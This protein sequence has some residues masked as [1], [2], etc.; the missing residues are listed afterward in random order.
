MPWHGYIKIDGTC[1]LTPLLQNHQDVMGWWGD[2]SGRKFVCDW[3]GGQEGTK[4]MAQEHGAKR[5]I[6]H[7]P[8]IVKMSP[9]PIAPESK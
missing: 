1:L 2:C 6:V 8:P 9:I 7:D 4:A 3:D 5:F